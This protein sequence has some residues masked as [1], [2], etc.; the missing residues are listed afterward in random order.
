[1]KSANPASIAGSAFSMMNYSLPIQEKG[2]V[3]LKVEMLR[4]AQHDIG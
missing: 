2:H 1:M 3:T 4:H